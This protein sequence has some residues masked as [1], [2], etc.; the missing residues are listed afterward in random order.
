MANFKLNSVTLATESGGTVTLDSG[1]QDNITRLGTVTSGGAGIADSVKVA[2][3]AITASAYI[4]VQGCFTSTYKF[5][6]LFMGGFASEGVAYT[7]IGY[8]DSSNNHMT[9]SYY[10][11]WDGM[12][13]SASTGIGRWSATT[14]YNKGAQNDT[15]GFRMINTWTHEYSDS[16]FE[17]Q[18]IEMSFYDP[19]TAKKQLC[20]WQSNYS[21]QGYVGLAHGV[22][23]QDTTTPKHGLRLAMH[24]S[25]FEANGHFA[26]Y[27][28]KI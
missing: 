22:G 17:G 21:Q 6:K 5:Y 15:D 1:V 27:G 4:D 23:M 11:I 10:T 25:N 28:Y 14:N 12:F 26:V 9:S 13:T 3:G 18:N 8:L 20:Y 2:S 7:E 16:G 19:N 24:T